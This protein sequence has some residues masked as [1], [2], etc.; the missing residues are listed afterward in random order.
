MVSRSSKGGCSSGS[1]MFENT[2]AQGNMCLKVAS[3]CRYFPC[4]SIFSTIRQLL[5][6]SKKWHPNRPQMKPIW[7]RW[8]GEGVLENE[9]KYEKRKETQKYRSK[10]RKT[11]FVEVGAIFSKIGGLTGS[12]FT[13]VLTTIV[14]ISYIKHSTK[15][16]RKTENKPIFIK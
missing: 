13:V 6:K 8:R 9:Q 12:A 7:P 2:S 14:I 10:I 16:S 1:T 5:S 11:Y 4:R 3:F 15:K